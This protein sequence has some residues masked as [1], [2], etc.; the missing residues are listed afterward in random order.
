VARADP[1][2]IVSPMLKSLLVSWAVI[3][4]AFAITAKLLGGMSVSGGFWAYVWVSAIFGLVNAIIGTFLRIV[5]LPLTI[6]TFGLFAIIVN[7][8]V[9]E[10]TDALTKH[11]TIDSFF[12]TA[13]WAAIILA[14]TTVVL[15]LI[16]GAFMPRK[17][18][19]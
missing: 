17:R 10:I 13:I 16:I 1:V 11:L 9:L 6:I 19:V 15:Y 12:W 2:Y 8:I 7:A 14:V 18:A 3:A 5:T 4:V